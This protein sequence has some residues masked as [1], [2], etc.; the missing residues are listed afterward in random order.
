MQCLTPPPAAVV[1][2]RSPFDGES[3][4]TS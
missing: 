4:K 2:D 1:S 3:V